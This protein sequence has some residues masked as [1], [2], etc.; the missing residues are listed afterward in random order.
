MSKI[1]EV[2]KDVR[3][4]Y[5]GIE[6]ETVVKQQ[7]VEDYLNM[8]YFS[9]RTN[10]LEDAWEDIFALIVYMDRTPHTSLSD[11]PWWEYS[12]ALEWVNSH[13]LVDGRFDLTLENA[14]R[15][16]GR[17]QSFYE[18]LNESRNELELSHIKEGYQRICGGK[19]LKLV[20]KIP[21]T[22]DEF[23]TAI[24]R[25][26]TED[27]EFS[28]SEFWLIIIFAELGE[29]W[30]RL[31]EELKTVPSIREKRKR[32]ASLRDK[33]ALLGYENPIQLALGQVDEA[34]VEDAERWFYSRR[35]PTNRATNN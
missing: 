3:N 6:C 20:K 2:R 12:V 16:I 11:L 30:E 13:V 7:C 5:S 15:L 27:V 29:S 34:D 21:Y 24:S 8:L 9:K 32:L 25:A 26:N 10:E 28:M 1:A 31:E 22:G 17:W 33:L 23:W 14:R 19:K 35:I 18:Y 4:Y